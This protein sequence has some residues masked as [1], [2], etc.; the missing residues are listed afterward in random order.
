[1]LVSSICFNAA[2][3]I[4]LTRSAQNQGGHISNYQNGVF[5]TEPIEWE[6]I[7][8]QPSGVALF[9][10]PASMKLREARQPQTYLDLLKTVAAK[11]GISTF[12]PQDAVP[13]GT[14]ARQGKLEAA[15][16]TIAHIIDSPIAEN[17][18]IKG[19]YHISP[20]EDNKPWFIEATTPH[21]YAN[22]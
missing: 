2:S 13:P 16:R 21:P 6:N 14:F 4:S 9:G 19:H 15:F 5:P 18:M 1:M 17:E 3:P 20:T 12:S 10:I 7:K 11:K 8:D 22:N